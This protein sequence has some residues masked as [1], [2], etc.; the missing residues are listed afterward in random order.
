[1]RFVAH[2]RD[3]QSLSSAYL[4]AKISWSQDVAGQSLPASMGHGAPFPFILIKPS[5]GR[6]TL[7]APLPGHFMSFPAEDFNKILGRDRPH[8]VRGFS[9]VGIPPWP[10]VK[11]DDRKQCQ[12]AQLGAE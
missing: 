9:D 5:V 3:R 2:G 11:I 12:A 8:S 6:E 7:S 4:V 1:M 10:Q